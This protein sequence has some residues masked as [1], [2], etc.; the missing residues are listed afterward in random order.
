MYLIGLSYVDK[1]LY[2]CYKTYMLQNNSIDRLVNGQVR[3]AIIALEQA[4]R[5]A[6]QSSNK[7][8]LKRL[9]EALKTLTAE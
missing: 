9:N 6:T 2:L 5:L 4:Q 3:K 8:I 7:K 1:S